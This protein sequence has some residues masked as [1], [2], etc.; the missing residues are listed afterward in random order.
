M[1]VKKSLFWFVVI[2]LL[3]VLCQSVFAAY[4]VGGVANDFTVKK[5]GTNTDVSLYDY[6]GHIIVLDFFAYWCG[7]CQTA[8][9]ELEP[10]IQ[11]YYH[12]RGG[13]PSSI[14]VKL[15]S[16][17]IESAN[18]STTDSYI[19]YFGLE[20]VWDDFYRNAFYAF[21]SQGYIP[22]IAIINGAAG[23]NYKQWEIL[24]TNSGYGKGKY[25]SFRTII[26]SV[27]RSYGGLKVTL[28][29]YSALNMGGQWNVDGGEWKNSGSVVNNFPE[30]VHTINYRDIKEGWQT[31]ISEHV[32][33]T[34][35]QTKSLNRRYTR[36]GDINIDGLINLVDFYMLA[37]KWQLSGVFAEDIDRNGS[38]SYGDLHLL[39]EYWLTPEWK[40]LRADS[41]VRGG[42]N[43]NSNFGSSVLLFVKSAPTSSDTYKSYLRFNYAHLKGYRV[44]MAT[45]KLTPTSVQTDR[46][47]G[48][49]LVE[50]SGEQWYEAKINWN[51]KPAA[52]GK[53][54]TFSSNSLAVKQPFYIDVTSL[55]NQEMNANKIATFQ[56]DALTQSSTGAN[57]FASREHSLTELRP[58]LEVTMALAG[59]VDSDGAVNMA[60]LCEIS[61]QWKGNGSAD[62][63]PG[64]GD[65]VVDVIDLKAVA[66]NWLCTD[67]RNKAD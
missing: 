64:G 7:P 67:V 39:A 17:N 27:E 41:Y 14:P 22:H 51:N 11:Q 21:S 47:L 53:T 66:E 8:S 58:R 42:D 55:L 49:S 28:G 56:I 54:A 34:A 15:I 9:S 12:D 37:N 5:H 10:Y 50:D 44:Q 59:D 52:S 46:T 1:P 48:I 25:Y 23:T 32:T 6:E 19:S 61:K 4:S 65:G 63:A 26:D 30:G 60:D 31:P 36:I 57:I 24:Y 16:M 3:P 29:P 18:P 2:A 33:I 40:P 13:N 62:I 35:G 43:S 45:L 20:T 38:V